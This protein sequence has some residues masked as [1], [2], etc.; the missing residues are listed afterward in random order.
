MPTNR[1]FDEELRSIAAEFATK[2]AAVVR[3]RL[4]GELNNHRAATRK[5]KGQAVAASPVKKAKKVIRRDS[6]KIAATVETVLRFIETHPGLN[7]EAI[8]KAVGGGG[9][10]DAL[11]RLR[12]AKRVKTTGNKRATRYQAAGGKAK[13][14]NAPSKQAKKKAATKKAPAPTAALPTVGG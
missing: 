7:A 1:T 2:V 13:K 14:K 11:A 4:M 9:V 5:P 8:A 6:A 10:S 3:G 12:A